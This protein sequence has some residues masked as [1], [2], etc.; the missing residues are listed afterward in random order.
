MVGEHVVDLA[1]ARQ[2]ELEPQS[3]AVERRMARAEK[4]HAFGRHS[5]AP[6][7]VVVLDRLQGDVIAEPLRLLVG[8]GMAADIDQQGGVIDSRALLLVEPDTLGQAHGDQ[9]LAQDV[10]HRLPEAEV[11]A[12][13]EGGYELRQPN[14]RGIGLAGHRATLPG[15]RRARHRRWCC[16]ER[17][18][19]TIG[20]GWE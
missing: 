4:T 6:G 3:E 9:A 2:H 16:L 19:R 5:Q 11:Y 7:L 17:V 1:M 18:G 10:L 14:L 8:I 13:R 20:S 12:Q 15:P